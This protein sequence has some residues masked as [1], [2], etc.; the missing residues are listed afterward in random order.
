[1]ELVRLTMSPSLMSRSEPKI[2]TPTLSTFEVQRHALNA[3]GEFDHFTGL[4]IVEAVNTGNTVTDGQHAADFG[5]FG[6]LTEVLDLV[7]QDRRNLCCLDTH[8][9]DLF[10][11]ILEGVEL[12]ADRRVDHL[13]AHFDDKTADETFID[14]RID[15]HGFAKARL[16]RLGQ[17]VGLRLGQR[18][19]R[20]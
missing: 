11:C 15:G 14:G 4:N 5:H 20:W 19:W 16:K 12:G 8:L 10:H 6:F 9:S 1:M 3:T 18:P 17:F 2:T 13:G 7:L